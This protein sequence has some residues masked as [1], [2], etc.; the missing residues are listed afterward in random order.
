MSA[1][2]LLALAL[3]LVVVGVV[4]FVVFTISGHGS[5]DT[6]TRIHRKR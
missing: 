5:G 4:A 3:G 2:R 6:G 1:R